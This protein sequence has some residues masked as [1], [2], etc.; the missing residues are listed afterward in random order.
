VRPTGG[1]PGFEAAGA[2]ALVL[3]VAAVIMLVRLS[4]I[5]AVSAA[6]KARNQKED[7]RHA[8]PRSLA[9]DYDQLG[10]L[11]RL[12]FIRGNAAR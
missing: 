9:T 3:S 6:W 5:R 4:R 10:L 11:R 1:K 2:V 8:R 12:G 7:D